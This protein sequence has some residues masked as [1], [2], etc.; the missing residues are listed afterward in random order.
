MIKRGAIIACMFSNIL[1]GHMSISFYFN[2]LYKYVFKASFGSLTI[3]ILLDRFLI[4][5]CSLQRNMI[6]FLIKVLL[7][8]LFFN[9][10]H[11]YEMCWLIQHI[12]FFSC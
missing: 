4:H 11:N 12:S 10:R 3:V 5:A 6:S 7:L 9:I 2:K 1:D 8:L